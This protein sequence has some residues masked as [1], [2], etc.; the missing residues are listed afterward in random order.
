[1]PRIEL[2]SQ[3]ANVGEHDAD[4]VTVRL[5]RRPDRSSSLVVLRGAVCPWVLRRRWLT[6]E[7]LD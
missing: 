3:R 1:M 2:T 4:D 7:D 6:P 5:V